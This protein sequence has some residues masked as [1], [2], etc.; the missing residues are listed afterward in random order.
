MDAKHCKGKHDSIVCGMEKG[1]SKCLKP[2]SLITKIAK[3]K[4]K[5]S[6]V[7]MVSQS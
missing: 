1:L 5:M 6:Q 2:S 3:M 7:L 4:R